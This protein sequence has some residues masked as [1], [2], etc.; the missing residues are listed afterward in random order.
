MLSRARAT[1]V[2]PPPGDI[3]KL[4][5]TPRNPLPLSHR[6]SVR[7]ALVAALLLGALAG[8][9]PLLEVPGYELSEGAALL[10]AVVLAP[11]LGIAA[12]RLDRTRPEPSVVAAW[13]SSSAL[14]S[15]LLAALFA[16]SAARA[17]FGPC[18]AL[19]AAAFFPVLALPSTLVGCALAVTATLAARGRRAM[20]GALYA[21]VVLL[22]VAFRL[23]GAY[24]GPAAFVL[25]PLLGYFPGPLYDEVVPLDARLLLARGAA[26]GWAAAVA[27][28]AALAHALLQRRAGRRRP[29]RGAAALAAAG[30]ALA[31]AGWLARA[32][33]QG[34]PD[35]RTAIAKRLGSRRDGPR[36]TIHVAAE[37][38]AASADELLAECEF[39]VADVAARLG[40]P[41]PPHVNVYVYRSAE[42]KRELVGASHTDFTRP[43]LAEI[44]LLDQP[45]PHPVL[46]HEIV[47]AVASVLAPGPLRLPAR[48]RLVPDLA[49]VEGLAVALE[50]PRSG[51]TVHQ[52]SR[53]AR[54]LGFLPDLGRILGPAGF[55]SQAPARAYTAAGSFLA[56]L[57][58]RYGPG[59]VD[60][61]Y[62][63]GDPAAAFGRPLPD[64]VREWQRS[65]DAV[66]PQEDLT[67]AAARWFGRGSL[68]QRRCARE[69]AILLRDAGTAAALGRTAEACRL[70]AREAEVD[71][72]PDALVLEGQVLAGAGE[73]DAAAAALRAAAERVP[74][75]DRARWAQLRAAEGDLRWRRDDVA[76][77]IRDWKEA[78]RYPFQRAEARLLA[79]K[80]LAAADPA[81]GPAV[82]AYLL[83]PGD[84]TGLVRVA[85]VDHPLATYLVGRFLL[86]RGERALAGPKLARAAAAGLPP[87][88]D[89]EARLSLAEAR[90][91]P[92]DEPLLAPLASAGEADRD[93]LDE[94]RRRCAYEEAQ[95]GKIPAGAK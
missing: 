11:W 74:P 57:L 43:W 4:S 51:F 69:A 39:H 78:S 72:A 77:A 53:A 25:D 42:E 89:L 58:Q 48:A 60:A 92:S 34:D 27:G 47:H 41:A 23:L 28:A 50:S 6:R 46:R 15:A 32:G 70:Y 76:G 75:E 71:Q 68:F 18:H 19:H 31:A 94:A 36:C 59:P 81:L 1:Q 67:V 35:L 93:R 83:D 21:A 84:L 3:S 88:I 38:P 29:L 56:Y 26:L 79:V 12:A 17:A 30:L 20:A 13:A 7:A 62:R 66:A 61:A 5:G 63:T 95:R 14:S 87:L 8:S 37:K 82:R 24:R 2:E 65:L 55:W 16:G 33:L 45:L 52:W 91:E 44:H 22:L 86:Q 90:C 64:L 80:S 85:E 54:D 10:A 9:L 49:L 40:I 73:L